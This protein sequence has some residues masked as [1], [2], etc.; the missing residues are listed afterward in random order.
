MTRAREPRQFSPTDHLA[1]E[2]IAAYVDGELRMNPYL[3]AAHHVSECPACAAEVDAQQ[4]ARIALQA[5]PHMSM[6]SSLLGLLSQ[7]PQCTPHDTTRPEPSFGS[8]L[9][10]GLGS[11]VGSRFRRR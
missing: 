5:S 1:S 7:I 9:R 10:H 6:P 2:A 11:V 8:G 4:Q 3:R